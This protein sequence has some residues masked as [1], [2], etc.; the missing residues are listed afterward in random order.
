MR[1]WLIPLVSVA[2]LLAAVAMP[3]AG[4]ERKTKSDP[5][6]PV[7]MEYV[8]PQAGPQ[9]GDSH[10]LLISENLQA[11]AEDQATA[12]GQPT[13][14]DLEMEEDLEIMGE[15]LRAAL[16]E[17]YTTRGHMI[18]SFGRDVRGLDAALLGE[19]GPGGAA[20]GRVRV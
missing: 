14:A 3:A 19:R 6:L 11:K 15:V 20:P 5:N 8:E 13:A 1:S 16:A 4:Q 12:E 7:R 17:L 18:L 10:T 9:D 2:C